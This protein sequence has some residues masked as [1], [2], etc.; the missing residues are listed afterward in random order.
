MVDATNAAPLMVPA[1]SAAGT[2]AKGAATLNLDSLS[3]RE[4][5]CELAATEALL[6]QRPSDLVR[7]STVNRQALIVSELHRR[8]HRPGR[9]HDAHRQFDAIAVGGALAGE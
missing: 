3:V 4:L 5:I 2:V 7:G 8:A 9:D 1:M 6:R